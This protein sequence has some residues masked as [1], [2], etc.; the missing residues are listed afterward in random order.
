MATR[1]RKTETPKYERVVRMLAYLIR[2]RGRRVTPGDMKRFLDQRERADIRS[3]QRDLQQLLAVRDS[4]VQA[5]KVKGKLYYSIE[6][7]MREKLSLPIQRNA[8]LALF[9]LKRLQPLFAP[10]ANT[11]Q[12]ISETLQAFGSELGDELF[13]DLDERL[14]QQTQILGEQSLLAIDNN[15]LNT[16]L[17][18]LLRQSRLEFTYRR[19]L[20][21][22]TKNYNVCPVKLIMSANQ[23]YL[24]A[25]F[26]PSHKSNYY[27]KVG[28]MLSVS[29][30]EQS[31]E[32]T[33]A[34]RKRIEDRLSKSFGLLDSADAPVRKV[35]L[36]FPGWCD[37]MLTETLFHPSQ[38]VSLKGDDTVVCSLEAP[39][40]EDLVRWVLGWG[41]LATVVTPR[42]L[43]TQLR[44]IG[45]ELAKRYRE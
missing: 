40:G 3:V 4:C 30:V 16:I 29:L 1:T 20:R 28:R 6:P 35:V 11:L 9:L 42:S 13:D 33:S 2:N 31:F 43:R 8:L 32:L 14:G 10:G 36:H 18:G 19:G 15:T 25:V 22:D 39:V 26:D 23:L 5:Q 44:A 38:K 37:T 17:E 24:V 7:D 34:Q 27:F 41:D 21:S 45:S 12:E